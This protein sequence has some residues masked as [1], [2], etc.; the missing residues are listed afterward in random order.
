MG[1]EIPVHDVLNKMPKEVLGP[2]TEEA[3]LGGHDR[4]LSRGAARLYVAWKSPLQDWK[5]EDPVRVKLAVLQIQ[6]ASK[7]PELRATGV[8]ELLNWGKGL[9]DADVHQYLEKAIHDPA[10]MVR[11]NAILAAGLLGR[12]EFAPF[13]KGVAKGEA[14]TIWELP[15]V[16]KEED[17]LSSDAAPAAEKAAVD[18]DRAALALGYL[19][20][21]AA[22]RELESLKSAPCTEVALALLGDTTRLRPEFFKGDWIKDEYLRDAAL[23]AAL[24]S[25]D[26][27][28]I[29]MA[30]LEY[31]NHMPYWERE[32]VPTKLAWGLIEMGSPDGQA[33]SGMTTLE[34]LQ[35]WV[36]G[37]GEGFFTQQDQGKR[38]Q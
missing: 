36:K 28:A 24:R 13:L 15:P 29:K 17:V 21:D 26:R 9:P 18:A 23:E 8:K 1:F 33:L 2:V 14:V 25:K 38:D 3:L 32:A 6:G 30:I 4:Q 34:E 27:A 31:T 11:A 35:T 16:P 22:K 37:P 10:P 7:N 12:S 20:Y 5:P 19:R